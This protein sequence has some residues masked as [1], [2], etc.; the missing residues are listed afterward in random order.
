MRLDVA[1]LKAFLDEHGGRP[2][3]MFG[4]TFMVWQY[5]LRQLYGPRA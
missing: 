1:G 3:L 5:L 4:F 2:F